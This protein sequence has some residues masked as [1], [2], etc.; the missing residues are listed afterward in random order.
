MT[1]K[2]TKTPSRSRPTTASS[3]LRAYRLALIATT[4]LTPFW[5]PAYAYAEGLPTGGQ[6]VQGAAQIA[7]PSASQLNVNQSSQRAVVNWEGFSVGQGNAVRFNQ[8]NSN[9][10]ILNRVTGNVGS[11]I[12]GSISANGHVYLVNPRGV[13]VGPTG[14][15]DAQGFVASSLQIEDDDFMA[16]RLRFNGNGA[17]AAVENHGAITVGAGGM[18]ALLG[19][20]V[21]N[22]GTIVAPLGRIGF[23]SGEQATLD[24]S[25]DGFLQIAVPSGSDGETLIEQAGRVSADGGLIEMRAA[26]AREAARRV[27]NLSGVTEARSVSGRDGRI[28]LGGGLGGTVRVTGTVSTAPRSS[29]TLVAAS[30]RPAERPNVVI[31]GR[32]IE[33]AGATINASGEG[34]GGSVRIGGDFAGQGPLQ[35][36]ETVSVDA[37][38]SIDVSAIDSG[39]G[40][41]AAIW[42]DAETVFL[43]SVDARG[44]NGGTG[45]F[46]EVSS[47]KMLTFDASVLVGE[48]G[49]LWLDPENFEICELVECGGLG[50][51]VT[52]GSLTT[53]IDGGGTAVVDTS[54]GDVPGNSGRITVTS[55]V[56]S[57]GTGT[58]LLTAQEDILLQA[59]ITLPNG[60]LE[61][62]AAE[63]IF[64]G[65]GITAGNVDVD[66]FILTEGTWIQSQVTPATFEANDFQL[67]FGTS[68]LRAAGDGSALDPFEINDV[69]ALQGMASFGSV[70]TLPGN[71]V[72]LESAWELG[73]D[74]DASGTSGWWTPSEGPP[75]GFLPIGESSPFTGTLEG[76]G[77]EITDLFSRWDVP[78]SGMF[79]QTDGAT[80]SNLSLSGLDIFQNASGS[81]E[82]TVE[83]G[84]LIAFSEFTD[85]VN[86]SVQG[87][88]GASDLFQVEGEGTSNVIIGGV[89]GEFQGGSMDGV[90][91]SGT[92]SVD[93]FENQ[94][95]HAGG[96]AG[97]VTSDVAVMTDIVSTGTT[98]TIEGDGD[99][100]VGGVFGSIE[101][102]SDVGF[103][104]SGDT[105]VNVT[106][107]EENDEA[108][109]SNGNIGGLVGDIG[110]MTGV[111]TFPDTPSTTVIAEIDQTEV[112]GSTV[113]IGGLVG[114][115]NAGVLDI[116]DP[117]ST[118]LDV[119]TSG[120]AESRVG[121]AV[122]LITTTASINPQGPFGP[123]TSIIDVTAE[124][125]TF[126]GGLVGRNEGFLANP[127][128]TTTITVEATEVS[129]FMDAFV[130]G[131]VGHNLGGVE[132]IGPGAT[133][134]VSGSADFAVGGAIGVNGFGADLNVV[135]NTFG[136]TS[137]ALGSSLSPALGSAV[138]GGLV[139]AN[140]GTLTDGLSSA[141]TTVFMDALDSSFEGSFVLSVGG[142]AGLNGGTI[143]DSFATGSVDVEA[144][145]I[146]SAVGGFTGAAVDPTTNTVATDVSVTVSSNFETAAG[147]F[148]GR[149]EASMPDT[150]SDARAEGNVSFT[151]LSIP[152]VFATPGV[153]TLG[154]FVGTNIDE[155]IERAAATG[156][157]TAASDTIDLSMGGF[158]GEN[159]GTI[160]D[161]YA[162]GDVASTGTV[163]NAGLEL[164]GGLVGQTGT[165]G[166]TIY[167]IS[168]GA[169]TGNGAGVDAV[170]GG[171]IA[172]NTGGSAIG[173]FW[174]TDTS[175]QTTSAGGTGLTT[176]ELQD[177]LGFV[178]L[179][180]S[181]GF[182]F[183]NVWAPGDI[184]GI[185]PQIYTI[186]PVVYAVPNDEIIQYGT[187]APAFT[188]TVFGG[189]DVFVFGPDGDTLDTTAVFADLE[190]PDTN[191][192]IFDL[193]GAPGT[194]QSTALVEYTVIYG[195]GTYEITPA[196]LEITTLDQTKSFGDAT[197]SLAQT[198]GQGWEITSGA[199]VTGDSIGTVPLASDGAP[200]DAP[201]G[202]YAITV[203]GDPTG[204]G[205]ANYEIT[206]VE[207]GQLTVTEMIVVIDVLI[208]TLDQRKTYGDDAFLLAET[209]GAGWEIVGEDPFVGTDGIDSIALTSD[210]TD[211]TA[212]VGSYDIFAGEISGSGLENYDIQ[213]NEV[214]LLFVDPREIDL[215]ITTLDQSR[216]YG[217]SS[218]L[219]ETEGVGWVQ[220]G[221]PDFVNGDSLTAVTLGSAG[222]D[223]TSIVGDYNIAVTGVTGQ[224]IENYTFN[225]ANDGSLA[226]TPAPI[227]L[228][229]LGQSNTYGN[230][231]ALNETEGVGWEIT[232]GELF[233]EDL[234]E[235]V[236]LESDGEAGTAPADIFDIISGDVTGEGL[237]NYDISIVEEGTL[238]VNTRS[239]VI[240]PDD[241]SKTEGDLF[242]FDGDEFSQNG[243]V[244][245]DTITSVDLFSDGAA[246]EAVADDSPFDI[247]GSNAQGEGLANYDIEFEVGALEVTPRDDEVVIEPDPID[248]IVP[249][250]DPGL[251]SQ[252]DAT[253]GFGESEALSGDG[254]TGAAA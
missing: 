249:P 96:V 5:L 199:L 227:T 236:G 183:E 187:D 40:G 39:A 240:T 80:I 134:N 140:F 106:L 110:S 223:G 139:G 176:A 90:T 129:G 33:L 65:D 239:L 88:V 147:G 145:S 22:T 45:G 103:D 111:L 153:A 221:T 210:G 118:D 124:T 93:T 16:G 224:G 251:P 149:L 127:D 194:A 53:V 217:L 107:A 122:G 71:P 120:F 191:V 72:L 214:G 197:F 86:V 3:R 108:I 64:P 203:D 27:V 146:V 163:G 177:T 67:E 158:A 204:V 28:V 142:L 215:T 231:F 213:I 116:F 97:L 17:S 200:V 233:N 179:A 168:T 244:N 87:S 228:T 246:E 126:V 195:V 247:L 37:A 165:G 83:V 220:S 185:Y 159:L 68:F 234:I 54:S 130:G 182:D 254:S 148:V 125:D 141:A 98:V 208:D 154:G 43:G 237:S 75:I 181:F 109:S 89:A 69:F 174:D 101:T 31:T 193:T 135:S 243:L 49:T 62:G 207:L 56:V 226:V 36:A 229:T 253:F 192:G 252:G 52:P 29:A 61:I 74:I 11:R 225:I 8:P 81:E 150:I 41:E 10:A 46:V 164:V 100:N 76:N 202:T 6:V 24:L 156:S 113:N 155:T 94:S 50:S 180:S 172:R 32:N 47:A 99:A 77:F 151:E 133:L 205:V 190:A 51:T 91:F 219:D 184:S 167:A 152:P 242:V 218:V 166:S 102:S 15:V 14:R 78:Q 55:D 84:G 9:S 128:S 162:T 209:E 35:R 26:T 170:E 189:P 82:D 132:S 160:V 25:G 123:V 196:P 137:V 173:V 186:D 13:V 121:G 169:V 248:V 19:G 20:K 238:T 18:A 7:Q 63:E 206:F 171:A 48:G 212:P 38:S 117:T 222:T 12:D 23:G 114:R 66:T 73:Q 30:P 112:L 230:D 245:N 188:G 34:G 92:V 119:T 201:V 143:T 157:V 175:G 57:T 42:S 95:V 138:V 44:A 216:V 4:A 58:L 232:A 161:V 2:T 136:A 131:A 178:T 21:S 60:T 70:P 198:E 59:D 235:T 79:A 250:R 211:V 1:T 105:T 241:Q 85:L 115:T 104:L 144:V